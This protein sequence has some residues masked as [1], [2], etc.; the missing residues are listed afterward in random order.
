MLKR[1]PSPAMVIACLALF[2][3]M[4]GTGYAA[5]QLVNSEGQATASK[6]HKAKRGPRGKKGKQGLTGATGPAGPTGPQGP[7]TAYGAFHDAFIELGTHIS[8]TPLTVATLSGL[9]AGSYAIQAKLVAD[10]ESTPTEDYTKCTLTAGADT[11]YADDYL[12]HG[13]TGDSFRAV[14]AMQVL[15]TFSSGGSAS[16]SCYHNVTTAL[17]F[18]QEIK[19]T[20]IKLGS[21]TSNTGV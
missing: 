6:K 17:A 10:S 3:A 12:G 7:S 13:V 21:I 1:L 14:Y 16:I 11:D 2:V 8:T 9:P 18:V 4:G 20:A 19:I 5:T 15:H